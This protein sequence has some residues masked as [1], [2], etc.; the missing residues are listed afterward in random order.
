V[1]LATANS[2]ETEEL[3]FVPLREFADGLEG[4]LTERTE[5]RLFQ[6]FLRE[7]NNNA[8]LARG[9]LQDYKDYSNKASVNCW[10]MN[11][12]ESY[13]MW[14]AY[15][16]RGYAIRTTFE[17]SRLRLTDLRV[18]SAVASLSI[19]ISHAKK[20]RSVTAIPPSSR[21]IFRTEMN[22]SSGCSS[23]TGRQIR[24]K[25]LMSMRR[26]SESPSTSRS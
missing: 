2:G 3:Y 6:F 5:A 12:V 19:S 26:P 16:D 11:D 22:G 25:G 18:Q 21:K 8:E 23:G 10:H 1:C 14:K 15:G 4:A 13:M 9:S 24:H 17:G 7:Y 20:C